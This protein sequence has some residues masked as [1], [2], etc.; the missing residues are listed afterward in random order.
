MDEI[1][2]AP[3]DDAPPSARGMFDSFRGIGYS[4]PAA[5]ADLID[6]S[7][8]AG[9]A[10]IRI[11]FIW[12]GK[13]SVI[14][15]TD[16]GHGMSEQ[17]LVEA[18]RPASHNPFV[19]RQAN[20]LGRFGLGLKTASLSQGRLLTVLTRSVAEGDSA[21]HWDLDHVLKIDKWHLLH[22]IPSEISGHAQLP[23]DLASGTMVVIGR[24]DRVLGDEI[25]DAVLGMQR[26]QAVARTVERHLSM[27]F[28]RFLEGPRPEIAITVNGD[29]ATSAVKPWDPFMQSHPTTTKTPIER[30]TY[31]G[32]AVEV[33]GFVLPNRDRLT[34]DQFELAEGP[35]GWISHEG[36][37]VYRGR[38]LLV[39]G[40]WLGLGSG[41]PWLQNGI[42]RLARLRLDLPTSGDHAWKVDIRKSSATPPPGLRSRLQGLAEKVRRDAK[43]VYAHRSGRS[44]RQTQERVMRAWSAVHDARGTTYKIDRTHPS[45]KRVLDLPGDNRP[46]IEEM[47]SVI[48]KTVPVQR[49]WMDHTEA[50]DLPAPPENEM[51]LE[52]KTSL[53][54][55]YR[56]MR[57][58]LGLSAVNAR[59]RLLALEPFASH[60]AAV[61]QLPDAPHDH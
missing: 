36:F 15:V 58:D 24:L 5:V 46:I 8:T 45:V 47:L 27:T 11:D 23:D 44:I 38:R 9:A 51:S 40:G 21:R 54:S 31:A 20:D 53:A 37:F 50:A 43:E 28:H 18:M 1:D 26:F 3:Y 22:G 42:H 34:T 13:N 25:E 57:D 39:P 10:N 48:E 29:D 32:G 17:R 2:I 52:E 41:R 61:S 49:I 35:G 12:D 7:I 60:P 33:Q 59:A 14:R 4:A 6:N 19:D 55:I 56:H 16:N 30:F